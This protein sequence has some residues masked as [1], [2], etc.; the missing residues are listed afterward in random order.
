M[1]GGKQVD[2]IDSISYIE[3]NEIM[4]TTQNSLYI[5]PSLMKK[6]T[7]DAGGEVGAT[8]GEAQMPRNP[9]TLPQSLP[10]P[11]APA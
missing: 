5:L 10:P 1:I 7:H 6:N 4:R 2:Y 3:L 8:S 9:L 11:P